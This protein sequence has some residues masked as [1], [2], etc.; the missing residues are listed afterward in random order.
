[1]KLIT[2]GKMRC[3]MSI[4]DAAMSEPTSQK[5]N[6]DQAA[7]VESIDAPENR[8]DSWRKAIKKKAMPVN[9]STAG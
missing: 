1:M 3:W 7:R 8:D 2:S 5:S 9:T 6:N 4:A